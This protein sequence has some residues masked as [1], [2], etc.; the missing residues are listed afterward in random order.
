MTMFAPTRYSAADEAT[1]TMSVAISSGSAMRP[2]V[3]PN[4]VGIA[5]RRSLWDMPIEAATREPKPSGSR[6]SPVPTPPGETV[7]TRTPCGPNSSLKR[8]LKA[9]SAA[10]ASL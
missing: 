8:L 5:E 3:T 7:F 1:N 6:H 10:L 9:T 2:E 4:A